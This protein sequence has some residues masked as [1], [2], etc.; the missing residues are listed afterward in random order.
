MAVT[1]RRKKPTVRTK[2][3][4]LVPWWPGYR[5]G[6]HVWPHRYQ[7]RQRRCVR[8]RW[9]V[10]AIGKSL[11]CRAMVE[12]EGPS[13]EREEVGI[14]PGPPGA[15]APSRGRRGGVRPARLEC[16][17]FGGFFEERVNRTGARRAKWAPLLP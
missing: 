5:A 2:M 17:R 3:T 14:H 6:P 13:G 9:R 12:K 1:T 4:A 15:G 8:Q 10:V 11:S 16:P 7:P